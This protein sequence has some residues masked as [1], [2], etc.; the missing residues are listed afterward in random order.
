[1]EAILHQEKRPIN[2]LRTGA[3]GILVRSFYHK[4]LL[5]GQFINIRK[6]LKLSQLFRVQNTVLL[7]HSTGWCTSFCACIS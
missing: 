6:L 1:M 2:E 3:V 7:E 5:P 4:L